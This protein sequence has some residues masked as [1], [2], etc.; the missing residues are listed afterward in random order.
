[1]QVAGKNATIIAVFF[2]DGVGTVNIRKWEVAALDKARAARLSEDYGLPFFLAMLLEIRGFHTREEIEGLLQGGALAD[3]YQMRDMDKA[4]ERIRQAVEGFEKIAVYG[5]YDADGVTATAML[6][7]YLQAMGADV[8]YYIPQR[9]GEGYGMNRGAVETLHSQGVGLII[10]VDNGISSMDE[11]DLARELGMDVVITDHHRPHQRLPQAAAVVDAHR[12]DD[13]S[14]FRELSGAGLVLKLLIALEDGDAGQV[15]SEYGDLAALGTIGDVV[16][17]FGE[18]RAIVQAGL[19]VLRRGG[20]PG[21]D[22]LLAQCGGQGE[23]SA[24]SLAFSMIPC[25]NATGRMGA[26]ERAVRLLTCEEEEAAQNLAAEIIE[27]NQRRRRIEGVIGQEA[28]AAIEADPQLRCARVIVVSGKEWHHGVV[29]IVA[30]RVTERTGKPCFVISEDGD[31]ARGSGRSI[32]G[33]SLFEAVSY[34]AGLLDRFGG[35]PMAAGATMRVGKVGAFREKIN[36]YAR[37]TCPRMP[38]QVLHLDCRLRPQA[39]TPQLPKD[40]APLEP[41]GSGSPQPVFGLY[42]MELR[43]IIPIGGGNHLRLGLARDGVSLRCMR[44]RVKPEDFPYCRGDV[45]DLAVTLEAKEYRGQEQLTVIIK[46]MKP[47]GL[48]ME[49]C[50]NSYR[51]Y[52]QY[53]RGEGLSREEGAT[54]APDRA[55]LAALYRLLRAENGRALSPLLLLKKLDVPPEGLGKVLVGLDMLEERG[56]IRQQRRGEVLTAQVLPTQGKV[57]I[58]ASPVYQKLVG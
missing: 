47:A 42:G 46:D 44:F 10:T 30:A 27:D 4:V 5:D 26:P 3:P 51:L 48:E 32:E 34:C 16:P 36:E 13:S 38:A 18:N 54:L 1:M 31:E 37:V 17:V 25:I 29:G 39:L 57:D 50:I 15:V 21:L 43:E 24:T 19:R 9:E 2:A 35:H 28:I 52:E 41:F 12:A 55:Q 53:C 56:L 58:F 8:T 22:A 7:S 49:P 11:V 14:P 45:V 33:F 23:V 20:R 6:F 40:L